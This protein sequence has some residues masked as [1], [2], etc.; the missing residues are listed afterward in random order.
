[1]QD[2]VSAWARRFIPDEDGEQP[3]PP[4]ARNQLIEMQQAARAD[5]YFYKKACRVY[6]ILATA[7]LLITLIPGPPAFF[8]DAC[9][10]VF[11]ATGTMAIS[12]YMKV[13]E[14]RA[15][16]SMPVEQFLD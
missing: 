12:R 11:I 6:V 8:R 2:R 3:A 4:S 7:F 1:M 13:A 10:C 14:R 15:E 9:F 5:L 16:L